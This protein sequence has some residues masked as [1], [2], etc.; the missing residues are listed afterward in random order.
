MKD[1]IDYAALASSFGSAGT[2]MVITIDPA[3]RMCSRPLPLVD[4][5]S[6][7]SLWLMINRAAQHCINLISNAQVN[8]ISVRPEQGI[9]AAVSGLAYF[10]DDPGLV[11]EMWRESYQRWFS[12]GI[13]GSQLTMLQ[14]VPDE[15]RT[16]TGLLPEVG[17]DGS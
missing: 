8:V 9:Y 5:D 16:W 2:V 14:V 6:D 17:A 7:G 3:G 13:N 12:T 1:P 10:R 15:F 11:R 4:M